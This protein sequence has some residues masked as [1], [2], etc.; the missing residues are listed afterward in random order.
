LVFFLVIRPSG[1]LLGLAKRGNINHVL[2]PSSGQLCGNQIAAGF[3]QADLSYALT[4]R[5]GGDHFTKQKILGHRTELARVFAVVAIVAK[6]K[7]LTVCQSNRR[8]VPV[9]A[10]AWSKCDPMPLFVLH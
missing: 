2:R 1:L 6:H 10:P 8:M 5:E 4:G 7:I 3:N 9:F